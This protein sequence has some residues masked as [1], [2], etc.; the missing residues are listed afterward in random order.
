MNEYQIYFSK[1]NLRDYEKDIAISEIKSI[2]P[3][4]TENNIK[5]DK[6]I[7]S[8][9]KKIEEDKLKRLTFFSEYSFKN[10]SC[11]EKKIV[12]N[13]SILENL[14]DLPD[15]V[16]TSN[17]VFKI[18]PNSTRE[19]R[20]LTHSF[21]EYKGRFYPQLAK[22]FMNF[23]N[24]KPGEIVLDPFCGSGTTLVESFLFGANAIGVDINPIAYLLTKAKIRSFYISIDELLKTK[25][26]FEQ[27]HL[28][29]DFDYNIESFSHA[30]DIEYLLRWFPKRNLKQILFLLEQFSLQENEDIQFLLKITLSNIFRDFSNQDPSQLRIRRRKTPP[31]RNLIERFKADL[32]SNI[33]SLIK[34]QKLNFLNFNAEI[35]NYLGDVRSLS[36]STG[37]CSSSIDLAITSPPYATALPYIDTDRLSLYVF[38]YTQRDSFRKLENSL[39]GNR[40][41]TKKSREL[42]DTELEKNFTTSI[43]PKEIIKLLE[44]IYYLNKNS[45]VGFR[46]KNTAA[47]L[48][49]YFIDMDQSMKQMHSV[50]KLNKYYFMVIG[51]NRTT[52]GNE[53]ISIPTVYFIGLIA[54]SNGFK[55]YKKIDMTVQQSYMIHSKN[56][57]NSESILI[58]GKK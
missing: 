16:L 7:L 8:T 44:R 10:S 14:K 17:L 6:I 15:E 28:T 43:L 34:F 57:I 36:S 13:Q 4:I 54:E 52:A 39:I 51:N 5:N 26:F 58:L 35:K 12:T 19:I 40:E 27:I 3:T 37:I 42:L 41:I 22:S 9:E 31:P 30:L 32:T 24:L 21:H 50:L 49:K 33:Q 48:F 29:N 55:L 1:Y 38:G 20:Y 56:A 23:A 11:I 25:S 18:R 46:R 45:N 53:E 47:L 2:V